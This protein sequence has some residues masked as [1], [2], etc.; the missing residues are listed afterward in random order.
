MSASIA[1]LAEA[2]RD[3][4]KTVFFGG[5]GT[6]TASGIPDFRSSSGLYQTE[7]E[8]LNPEVILSRSFF[9]NEPDKFY[10]FL[11]GHM[12]FPEAKPNGCHDALAKL[13]REGLLHSV[14][15]QNI[16]GL[17]QLAGSQRV[18]ELHGNM[19]RY[20][21]LRCENRYET[22]VLNQNGVPLCSCGGLLK[23]DV[24]LYE[25]MLD[26]SVVEGAVEAIATA[27]VLI[28]GGTSLSVYPAAGF[29]RYFR[30]RMLV[31]MNQTPTQADE[32]AHLIFREPIDEVMQALIEALEI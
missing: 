25:E 13:E 20:A 9:Y 16:D 4:Q 29:I 1:L 14:I 27:D 17:H 8:G 7:F 10:R 12:Y 15:T 24:T 3:S 2:I 22:E 19:G 23:P 18:I 11:K 32:R 30:G 31:V 6:S 28:I 5:A 26:E 21:C